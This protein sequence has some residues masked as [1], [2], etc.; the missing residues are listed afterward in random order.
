MPLSARCCRVN[1]LIKVIW[2]IWDEQRDPAFRWTKV[3]KH[4][5]PTISFSLL[6]SI[7]Y[8]IILILIKIFYEVDYKKLYTIREFCSSK[9]KNC[10]V[11]FKNKKDVNC[12]NLFFFILN[13]ENGFL[14]NFNLK[15]AMSILEIIYKS[16]N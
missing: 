9:M 13:S 15:C 2:I 11:S 3:R 4:N 12:Q 7:Y 14:C 6:I 8:I 1:K 10:V 16:K 5:C